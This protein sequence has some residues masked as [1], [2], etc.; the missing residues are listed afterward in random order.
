MRYLFLLIALL[1]SSCFKE[2]LYHSQSYVFGTLVDISIYGETDEHARFLAN[3]ILEDFQT[4]HN[5]LHAWK[6]VSE[7]KLGELGQLN[8]AFQEGKKPT[9]ISPEL[10]AMLVDAAALSLKSNGLFNPAIGH[11]IGVW[12]FQRD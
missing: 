2:P 7:N 1:L 4:L 8:A 12:G 5:Q 3:H 6:P 11:L 9:A 10:A